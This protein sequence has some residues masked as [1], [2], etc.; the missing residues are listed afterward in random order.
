MPKE[1]P[2]SPKHQERGKQRRKFRGKSAKEE[3]LEPS[4]MFVDGE[5]IVYL[6]ARSNDPY[7]GGRSLHRSWKKDRRLVGELGVG[8]PSTVALLAFQH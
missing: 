5:W 6:L 1:K 3:C 2:E 7:S 4:K 8:A